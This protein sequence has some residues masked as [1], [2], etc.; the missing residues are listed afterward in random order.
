[1]GI[2]FKD[3]REIGLGERDTEQEL[4]GDAWP[5]AKIALSSWGPEPGLGLLEREIENGKGEAA[6]AM[7]L[8]ERVLRFPSAPI[9]GL[10]RLGQDQVNMG[11]VE[12]F[13]TL[14]L[15][16]HPKAT[17]K[18]PSRIFLMH[19]GLNEVRKVGLYYEIA[20]H[21]IKQDKN[22]VCLLRPFPGHLTRCPYSGLSETPLDHYLWDGLH[23]FRQFLRYMIE[24]RW[25]LSSIV[26][27]PTYRCVSG[28]GLLVERDETKGSRLDARC[29]TEAMMGEWENLYGASLSA[30]E[31]R[32]NGSPEMCEPPNEVAFEQAIKSLR[33]A[34]GLRR[35]YDSEDFRVDAEPEL[36]AIGYSLGGFTAQSVFMS[37]PFLFSSCSTLLSGGAMRELAPTAFADPE[38]WQSVLHSL[39]YELDDAMMDWRFQQIDDQVPEDENDSSRA[40]AEGEFEARGWGAG[41][42][43]YLFLYLKRTF[44]EVFEQ[45]YRGSF[46]SRLVAFRQRM[47]FVV[48]GND[49]I[50]PPQSVLDSGPPDG[51]NML[52][53]GGL[54]HF[55]ADRPHDTLE[56]EQRE[57][58]IPEIARTIGL[59]ANAAAKKHR[60]DL[61]KIWLGR[62][63]LVRQPNKA[64]LEERMGEMKQNGG[65]TVPERLEVE[66]GGTLPSKLF[67]RSL[68]DLLSRATRTKQGVLFI[69]RN[70]APTFLLGD[71]ALQQHASALFH[72]EISIVD[73][74]ENVRTR[75]ALARDEETR[76]RIY[77]ILP[78]NVEAII[79]GIDAGLQ[80]PSQSESSGEQ[81]DRPR[82]AD[83]LWDELKEQCWQWTDEPFGE[84]VRVFK[85]LEGDRD[86]AATPKEL[87]GL[88][89]LAREWL[90]LDKSSP[91]KLSLPDCWIWISNQFMGMH[92]KNM[93]TFDVSQRL[94][95]PALKDYLYRGGNR[96]MR[97]EAERNIATSLKMDQLR[98][99]G[100]S[101]AR[102][103]PRFRGR[104]VAEPRQAQE[105][106]LRAMLCVAASIPYRKFIAADP[107]A[108]ELEAA[109]I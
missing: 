79:R 103:N 83:R 81:S 11:P 107:S 94:L 16:S 87:A 75:R 62:D 93:A 13:H 33:G 44:Y 21:L 3:A 57:F 96:K 53:I 15:I 7:P 74:V 102:F 72:D 105:L 32:R 48:G 2:S 104:I 25:L 106:L 59:L 64:Q 95:Y 88:S 55:L 84:T 12:S 98:I 31:E 41:I 8:R 1:M 26:R 86:S 46:Q 108:A 77:M 100:V 85:G 30:I 92:G 20:S 99:V 49:P 9:H 52:A 42:D 4:G 101:R 40:G 39:R 23:L 36:H 24:T 45:E 97:E 22:T 14:R 29:L 17:R 69:L 66:Q 61:A 54:G 91:V 37:W 82:D 67:Q 80:H 50:V 43:P 78:G 70:E 90:G 47:L 89:G 56:T 6:L 34:L 35:H 76:E 28:S 38:E 73:Y 18:M 5:H 19:N 63:K 58:W 109:A 68:D 60:Q 10:H 65:L 27:Y 51:I 71:N